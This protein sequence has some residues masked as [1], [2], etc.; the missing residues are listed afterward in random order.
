MDT[1]ILKRSFFGMLAAA[2]ILGT[3]TGSAQDSKKVKKQKQE[4]I[5]IKKK[6]R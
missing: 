3:I 1:L 5:I 4:E 6:G 2:M